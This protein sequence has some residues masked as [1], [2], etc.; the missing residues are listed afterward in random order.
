MQRII[1][2]ATIGVGLCVGGAAFAQDVPAGVVM[3]NAANAKWV[4]T[5]A[6]PGGGIGA[7]AQ[8]ASIIGDPAKPGPYVYVTKPAPAE[9]GQ[10]PS[11]R[12]HT[13]PDARTYQVI[14]GT[15]YVGFGTKLDESKLIALPAGSYY[16]E[17]A[18]VPH[19]V[20]VKDP[21]T[22]VHISGTGPTRVVPLVNGEGPGE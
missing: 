15:W 20:V 1:G 11:S 10:G 17:P 8:S 4:G 16:T 21:N 9:L 5:P 19:F 12:P 6:T 3:F 2:I 13:H 14:S 7:G 18:G 22:V